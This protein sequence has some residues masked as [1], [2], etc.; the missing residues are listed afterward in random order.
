M[1][2]TEKDRARIEEILKGFSLNNNLKTFEL[3]NIANQNVHSDHKI[4]TNDWENK[5]HKWLSWI[6]DSIIPINSEDSN[7]EPDFVIHI[8]EFPK[9][10]VSAALR[11]MEIP[12][13][14]LDLNPNTDDFRGHA[15]YKKVNGVMIVINM[16]KDIPAGSFKA[17]FFSELGRIEKIL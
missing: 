14:V 9:H 10:H 3:I 12:V 8:K 7:I 4:L 2:K 6:F 1:F 17:K 11:G 15:S 5:A 16:D 13:K